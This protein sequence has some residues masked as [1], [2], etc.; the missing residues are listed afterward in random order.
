MNACAN[1]LHPFSL[2]SMECM[3]TWLT[4]EPGLIKLSKIMEGQNY[5]RHGIYRYVASDAFYKNKFKCLP[6]GIYEILI[7]ILS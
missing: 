5:V 6:T 1:I 4:L 3:E 2:G 7:R